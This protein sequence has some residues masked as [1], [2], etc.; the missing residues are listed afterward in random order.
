W[1]AVPFVLLSIVHSKR[2]NYLLPMVTPLALLAAAALPAEAGPWLRRRM[3]AWTCLVL[4]LPFAVG[5]AGLGPQTRA[6]VRR[7]DATGRSWA[8]FHADPS[9]LEFYHHGVVPGTPHEDA[10]GD[11]GSGP[12]DPAPGSVLDDGGLLLTTGRIL[13]EVEAEVDDAALDVEAVGRYDIVSE[14]PAAGSPAPQ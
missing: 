7:L 5:L 8:T 9:S 13:S 10:L 14:K 1:V 2:P 11:D 3:T 4:V 12:R 6:I